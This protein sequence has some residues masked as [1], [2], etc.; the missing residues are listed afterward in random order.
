MKCLEVALCDLDTDYILKFASQ[1]TNKA[2]VNVHI[3][4]NVEAFFSD[5]GDFDI[6]VMTEDFQE[7][8][9]FKTK[10]KI[11]RKY[12]LSEEPV[13]DELNHIYKYQSIDN[14]FTCIEEL[15]L[16]VQASASVK[17]SNEKSKMVCVYS[18]I[19]HELQLP[20]AM[21]L[22]QEYKTEGSVLFLD[23]EEISILP[24]LVGNACE[25]N[26]LDLLYEVNAGTEINISQYV[27]NF[28]GCDYINPFLNPNEISEIDEDTWMMFF[29][30]LQKTDYDVIVVLF[31]RT[32]NGFGKLLSGMKKLYVLG[33]PGDYFKKGQQQF[34]E[35]LERIELDTDVE[36]VILPMSAGNL[37]DG[38]YQI[39]ELLQGNLGMFVRKLTGAKKK[40]Y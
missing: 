15:R 14:I 29:E 10:G 25:R 36:S 30:M 3:F 34:F 23:L 28:F 26:L 39:E 4:T 9:E 6:A 21:A 40:N 7:I 1:L 35:Y 11:N 2:K 13:E 37:S 16:V 24:A 32:I 5:E 12:F 38:T 18:P 8:T 17:K 33:R 22:S 19:S 31:G 20:F 27:R